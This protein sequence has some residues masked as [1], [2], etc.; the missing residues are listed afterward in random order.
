MRFYTLLDFQ[1]WLTAL[2][3]GLLSA[4]VVHV[5][6]AGFWTRKLEKLDDP[7][8]FSRTEVPGSEEYPPTPV[9][10]ILYVGIMLWVLGY[11]IVIGLWG[12]PII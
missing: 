2:C 1:H 12:G 4:L 8:D 5:A 7:Y 11:M 6:L 10:F 3:L 9:L